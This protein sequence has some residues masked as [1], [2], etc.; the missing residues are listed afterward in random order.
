MEG[1]RVNPG[2]PIRRLIGI[3]HAGDDDRLEPG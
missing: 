3:V 2:R 1:T